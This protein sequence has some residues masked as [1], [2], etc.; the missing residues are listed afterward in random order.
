MKAPK[1]GFLQVKNEMWTFHVGRTQRML[2]IFPIRV[3][4]I[5]INII[6]ADNNIV[7]GWKYIKYMTH[8][9]TL[10][11]MGAVMVRR[12]SLMDSTDQHI[13]CATI[14]KQCIAAHPSQTFI[15]EKRAHVD[16]SP[17][18]SPISPTL[19]KYHK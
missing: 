17:L 11:D 6:I 2:K 10:H 14:M 1:Q 3:L 7:S 5:N 8:I 15:K 12:I 19:L 13:L 4:N 9:R 16:S 18:I